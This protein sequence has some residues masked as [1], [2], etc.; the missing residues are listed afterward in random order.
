MGSTSHVRQQQ[1][2][3]PVGDIT[4]HRVFPKNLSQ[5]IERHEVDPA[6]LDDRMS[7][8]TTSS[9]NNIC[10][11]VDR[12]YLCCALVSGI[13]K[14]SSTDFT[15]AQ[16]TRDVFSDRPYLAWALI[17]LLFVSMLIVLYCTAK[18]F[19]ISVC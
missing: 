9:S 5:R 18:L 1:T 14:N 2:G 12:A 19:F 4:P 6:Y 15:H 8:P 11:V 10:I 13:H 16:H 17:S 7:T 3:I